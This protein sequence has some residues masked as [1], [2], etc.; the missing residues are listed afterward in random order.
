[1]FA[2]NGGAVAAL[3]QRGGKVIS[4]LSVLNLTEGSLENAFNQGRVIHNLS[5]GHSLDR[6]H[7]EEVIKGVVIH[8]YTCRDFSKNHVAFV[9]WKSANLP[10]HSSDFYVLLC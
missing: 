1:M 2:L 6:E 7:F 8:V 3:L 4:S 5:L 10:P 9:S